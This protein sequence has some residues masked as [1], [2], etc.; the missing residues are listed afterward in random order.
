VVAEGG[1]LAGLLAAPVLLD[2]GGHTAVHGAQLAF[3][4]RG[5]ALGLGVLGV[6]PLGALRLITCAGDFDRARGSYRDNLV[7]FAR[8]A[9][10][11]R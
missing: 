11:G 4:L 3:D 9:G 2:E 8:L 10:A 6:E 7:V 5:Q 1:P